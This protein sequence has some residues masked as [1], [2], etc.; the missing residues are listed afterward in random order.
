MH[1]FGKEES[2][3]V[4]FPLFSA[5]MQKFKCRADSRSFG[6]ETPRDTILA[7]HESGSHANSA[8]SSDPQVVRSSVP[9]IL[10]ASADHGAQE[11]HPGGKC[12]EHEASL[13]VRH[14]RMSSRTPGGRT[15]SAPGSVVGRSEDCSEGAPVAPGATHHAQS[16]QRRDAADQ[17][18][19]ESRI[20][21][22]ESQL[23]AAHEPQGYSGR[24]SF[25]SSPGGDEQLLRGHDHR[26]RQA[27]GSFIHG[28][29]HNRPA[30]QS[31]G[32]ARSGD[33]RESRLEA[34]AVRP[35]GEEDGTDRRTPGRACISP[36]HDRHLHASSDTTEGIITGCP[37]GICSSATFGDAGDQRDDATDDVQN[38]HYGG[39]VE[40]GKRGCF[41]RF[42]DPQDQHELR[43][44]EDRSFPGMEPTSPTRGS[45][46]V[47][48][49]LIYQEPKCLVR[50]L[51]S[52][53]VEKLDQISWEVTKALD[54]GRV[55]LMEVACAPESLLTN[56]AHAKGLTAM[57]ASLFNGCDLTT[58]EGLRKTLALV[59]KH[60]PVHIWLSTECGAFSPIQNFNQRTEQQQKDL[61]HKQREARKQHIGGMVVAYYGRS[62]GSHVHWEWSRRCRAWKWEHMERFR[63]NLNTATAVI[64]GCRVGLR[65][66]RI[67]AFWEKNGGSSPRTSNSL[68]SYNWCVGVWSVKGF[69]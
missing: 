62:I 60:R 47:E 7:G 39:R 24:A 5:V 42:Q 32:H 43:I 11:V 19:E 67:G 8:V 31:V 35:V 25:G 6:R 57:R 59:K 21:G 53:D 45:V 3:L 15:T 63:A 38:A 23:P 55:F 69:I 28:G 30:L 27:Q 49:T 36:S 9:H 29:L 12:G 2:R 14:Q 1:V 26:V 13:H 58:P 50:D 56:E 46:E 17:E 65:I 64:S 51:P 52:S 22:N 41:L 34:D 18:W 48:P 4:Q 40:G 33:Q 20:G 61:L 10:S 54:Y 66:L 68:R 16:G 44:R 37:P